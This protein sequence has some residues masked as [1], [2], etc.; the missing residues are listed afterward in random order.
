[1]NYPAT[2]IDTAATGIL[3]GLKRIKTQDPEVSP[4]SESD[5]IETQQI[6]NKIYKYDDQSIHFVIIIA[7]IKNVDINKLK[8]NLNSFNVEFFRLH[9]FDNISS[10][11]LDDSLQMVTIT[12]FEN[13]SKAMDYYNL[14]NADKKHVKYLQ[15]AKNTRIYAISDANYN[16][17]FHQKDKRDSYD[18]FFKEN[19]LK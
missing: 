18:E 13:K 4:V 3:E 11:F 15:E 9:K 2:D 1:L 5:S 17:F 12:H 10:F 19:Y 14:L 16:M 8:G 7:N 6:G